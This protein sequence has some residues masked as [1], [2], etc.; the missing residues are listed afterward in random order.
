MNPWQI[1]GNLAAWSLI[2]ILVLVVAMIA[3]AVIVSIDRT[4]RPKR[5]MQASRDRRT[6]VFSGKRPS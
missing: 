5:M 2:V 3:V 6:T 1:L 4:L